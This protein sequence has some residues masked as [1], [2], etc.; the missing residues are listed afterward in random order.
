[1]K[2]CVFPLILMVALVAGCDLRTSKSPS[3][4][5]GEQE[6]PNAP[7]RKSGVKENIS[8]AEKAAAAKLKPVKDPVAEEIWAANLKTRQAY[9]S[10]R[11]DE[12][13]KEA[14][15]LRAKKEVFGNGSWK[16]VQFYVALA[17]SDD[18]PE[19]MWQLHD[20]IH[21]EWIAARPESITAR[22][23]YAEFLTEYAWHARGTG[24][25]DTVKDKGWK[26]F[27]ERLATARKILDEARGLTEKDPHWWLTALT[28]ALGQGWSAE[29]YEVLLAEAHAFEPKFWGYDTARAYS[30]LPRWHGEPGD[31]EKFAEAA[32][33]RADGLG[34]EV[35]ARIVIRQRG[36]YANVFRESAAQWPQAREGLT[37]LLQKYP[38]SLGLLSEAAMLATMA[39]DRALAKDLFDRLGDRYLPSTWRKPERFAHFRNWAETGQW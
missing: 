31:W 16:I 8:S 7:S 21:Q 37:V 28:V 23:A 1:M 6:N 17:C 13:E 2:A 14:A 35:Y 33:A 15:E 20:R 29:Q 11:F 4:D 39:E 22:V 24:Y 26:L 10:R 36:F 18:E 9:N 5:G 38:D 34:A 30:L 32:A 19:S 3:G 12:L 25:A 27:G